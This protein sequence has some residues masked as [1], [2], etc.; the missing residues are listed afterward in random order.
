M[1]SG[2]N[3]NRAVGYS[4]FHQIKRNN[5]KIFYRRENKGEDIRDNILFIAY[6]LQNKPPPNPQ[7]FI[8]WRQ[9]T[10]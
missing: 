7:A 6:L 9:G 10:D 2:N 5:N 4:S 1:K 8:N 3:R